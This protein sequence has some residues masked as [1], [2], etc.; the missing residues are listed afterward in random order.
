MIR[1]ATLGAASSANRG[2][3]AMLQAVLDQ[4]PG[5]L[6][7]SRVEIL[8]THPRGDRAEP[9]RCP[10]GVELRILSARPLELLL[11]LFPLALLSAAAARVGIPRRWFART[12]SLRALLEA[13]LVLD[14]AGISFVDGRGLPIL[15]YN[16]LMTG[17]PI[18]LGRPVVKCSQAVGPFRRPLNRALA[19]LVLRRTAAVLPRGR[20]SAEHLAELGGVRSRP[21][22]D[23]AFLMRTS[24]ED[25]RA[26]REILG[27]GIVPTRG[28]A[29]SGAD[30]WITVIPSSV[31]HARSRTLGIDYPARMAD[32]IDGLIERS[33]SPVALVPHALRPGT[34][35]DRMNDLPT[36]REIHSRLRHRD[37]C[38]AVDDRF[39]PL[40]PQRLRGV[41]AASELVVTSRFH[42]MISAL[43]TATPVL[44]LGWSH[45][46]REVMREFGLEDDVLDFREIEEADL[47]AR[48]LA[49]R[50]DGEAVREG[51]RS[52]L[53]AVEASARENIRVIVEQLGGGR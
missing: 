43:A 26:A 47:V 35:L 30:R 41:V 19:R 24:E 48:C 21:A 7:P 38:L 1:I 46:Y 13:D 15:V 53:P 4:L 44:V 2:A 34:R 12:A 20:R 25:C 27:G 52:R 40:T 42:G 8:T 36:L 28:E 31:V 37:R 17:L 14:L 39:G 23:L 50:D 5:H 9:P 49:L 3:A 51:I 16:T 22:A 6:G 11:L 10:E 29:S 32:F 33:G 45:K 18:L